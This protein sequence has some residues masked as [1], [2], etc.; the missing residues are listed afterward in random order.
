MD[1]IETWKEGN[2][3]NFD[4][5]NV[6]KIKKF[7]LSTVLRCYSEAIVDCVARQD[8]IDNAFSYIQEIFQYYAKKLYRD[9]KEDIVFTTIYCLE[10]LSD[11]SLDNHYLLDIWGKVLNL[12][13][14]ED[15]F[16]YKDLEKLSNLSDEQID[17]I[18][19]VT[20]KSVIESGNESIIENELLKLSFFKA[21]KNVFLDKYNS[22]KK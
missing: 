9:D 13:I 14:R 11:F 10:L 7:G 4:W 20:C 6:E 17:C 1:D 8:D 18:I 5:N 12:L 16:R 15:V 2:H 22:L 19:S 3:K 21:S